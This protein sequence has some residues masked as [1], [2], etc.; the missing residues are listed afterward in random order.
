MHSVFQLLK[1]QISGP[2]TTLTESEFLG[3]GLEI[4]ILA[5]SPDDFYVQ[6]GQVN[7]LL[8]HCICYHLFKTI[9]IECLY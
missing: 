6:H 5:R 2:Y 1:L 3:I 8:Q 7:F 4:S 9:F